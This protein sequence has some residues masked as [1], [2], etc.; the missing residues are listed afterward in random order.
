M[1]ISNPVH[2]TID[3]LISD[4]PISVEAIIP[5][6]E[7]PDCGAQLVF[8]G[9]T[10][11]TTSDRVTQSLSYD[12]YQPM[13]E[14][15]LDKL[16]RQA[17]VQWHLFHV[18]IH[19]RIGKVDIGQPSIIVAVSSPHRKPCMEAV[20]WLMDQIKSNV[21]IWKQETYENNDTTWVHP[22]NQ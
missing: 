1:T 20:P 18:A 3:I 22:T 10:R 12:A 14:R 19:H 9:T 11:R 15:E 2:P 17:A 21:P 16:A 8:I 6:I 5:R 13:A 4:Q 7:D